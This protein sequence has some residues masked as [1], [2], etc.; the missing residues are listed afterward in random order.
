MKSLEEVFKLTFDD[1]NADLRVSG[2]PVILMSNKTFGMINKELVTILGRR[3]GS[4]LYHAGYEAGRHEVA[5]M[6]KWWDFKDKEEMIE[7]YKKQ[8]R[9]F[10]WLCLD[11]IEV[12]M[13]KKE[14]RIITRNNFE[15]Q[16]YQKS[17]DNPVCYFISGYLCGFAEVAFGME[18]LRCYEMRCE[19]KGNAHCEFRMK[20]MLW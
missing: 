5:T 7:A 10:G 8:F 4:L 19:G 12:D 9:R 17:F 6:K 11:S 20:P 15:S 14:V 1:E 13:D 2:I 3:G 18:A 16:P